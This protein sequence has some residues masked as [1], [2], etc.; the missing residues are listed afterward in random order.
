MAL[1]AVARRNDASRATGRTGYQQSVTYVAGQLRDAGY[2]PRL[3]SFPSICFA[4]LDLLALSASPEPPAV[5]ARRDFITLRYSGS[6]TVTA[7]VEPSTRLPL[8]WLPALGFRGFPRG[9]VALLRRGE[10]FFP[11]G[12]ECGVGRR[13]RV[14]IANEGV[15]G[16]RP[17]AATLV[18]PGIGIPVL[19]S[20]PRWARSS[21]ARPTLAPS[22]F[23]S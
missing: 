8:E 18:R 22:G 6:G 2:R 15:P 1:A 20:R 5:P 23:G 9:A 14:L 4:R 16:H 12:P 17:V 19:G 10:C 7:A 13:G 11:E 3:E 21:R